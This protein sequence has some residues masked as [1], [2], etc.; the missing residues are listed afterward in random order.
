MHKS[1]SFCFQNLSCIQLCLAPLAT[2]IAILATILPHLSFC[3][4]LRLVSQLDFCSSAFVRYYI[5]SYHNL[6]ITLHG[7]PVANRIISA[8]FKSSIQSVPYR[9]L[10]SYFLSL[11]FNHCTLVTGI[12]LSSSFEGAKLSPASGFCTFFFPPA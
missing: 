10:R 9:P 8:L 5:R 11:P 7:L 6:F 12:F 1:Y 4:S 3:S 2:I